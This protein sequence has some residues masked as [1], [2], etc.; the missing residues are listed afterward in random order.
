MRK[1]VLGNRAGLP[2]CEQQGTHSGSLLAFP[3][4]CASQLLCLVKLLLLSDGSCITSVRQF[5][6]VSVL[7]VWVVFYIGSFCRKEPF[8]SRCLF[9][10]L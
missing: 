7:S 9:I 8:F 5:P 4:Q 2:G 3:E 10:D 6:A 1:Q